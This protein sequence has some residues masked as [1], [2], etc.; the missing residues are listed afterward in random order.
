LPD[1]ASIVRAALGCLGNF[2]GIDKPHAGNARL[3]QGTGALAQPRAKLCA[4]R[5]FEQSTRLVAP[6]V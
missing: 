4:P 1:P 2:A 6:P 3:N 5:D